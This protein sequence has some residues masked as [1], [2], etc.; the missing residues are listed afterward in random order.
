MSI[1]GTQGSM[2]FPLSVTSLDTDN[3]DIYLIEVK[4]SGEEVE[5][6]ITSEH[7]CLTARGELFNKWERICALA[8]I[9]EPS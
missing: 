2:H 1:I 4:L 6:V 7:F 9:G 8:Q 5:T 3:D